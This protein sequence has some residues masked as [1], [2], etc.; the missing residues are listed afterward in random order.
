MGYV[1]FIEPRS[2]SEILLGLSRCI[3][4]REPQE[5]IPP[6]LLDKFDELAQKALPEGVSYSDAALRLKTAT[7][8]EYERVWLELDVFC[9][10]IAQTLLH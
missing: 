8:A 7:G 3:R 9:Q 5:N 6:S 1:C 10:Q 4:K 2:D